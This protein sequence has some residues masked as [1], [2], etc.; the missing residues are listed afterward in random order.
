M[1]RPVPAPAPQQELEMLRAQA[2]SMEQALEDC[3]RRIEELSAQV[4]A[5]KQ[6]K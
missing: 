2:G 4:E 5:E 6:D 1:G 3:R